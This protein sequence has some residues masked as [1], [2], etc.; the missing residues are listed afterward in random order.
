M[1][2]FATFQTLPAQLQA[3][4]HSPEFVKIAAYCAYQERCH[5]EVREKLDSMRVNPQ[6]QE[7]IIAELITQNYLNEERFAITFAGGKFRQKQ[8]GKLK[9]RQMLKL[10]AI[11]DYSIRKA[12]ATIEAEAYWQALLG[13]ATHKKASLKGNSPKEQ[14][15]LM[16]YLASKGYEPDLVRE[17]VK[18]VW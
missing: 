9:I 12:L 15:S 10:K 1:F 18:E 11:S 16:R 5:Q 2:K 17:A 13:L 3:M 14:A 4:S 8:W 6:Q 7:E